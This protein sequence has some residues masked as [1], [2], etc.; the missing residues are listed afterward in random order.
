MENWRQVWRKGVAPLLS[1]NA[2]AVLHRAL[3][4]DDP[5]L[6][7]GVT[8]FPSPLQC[9]RDWPCEAACALG[10]CGWQG[11]GLET[12]AEVELFFTNMCF[13]IDQAMG[14]PAAC[15]YFLNFWDDTP[16]EELRREMIPEVKRE[17][18]RRLDV[19]VLVNS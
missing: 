7:Q 2:L 4:E 11:E 14:E 10:Y 12:V 17:Q 19:A 1:D 6:M 5:C 9:V 16:R 15:R 18:A 3:V 13:M 8:T